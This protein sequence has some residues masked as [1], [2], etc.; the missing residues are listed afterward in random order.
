MNGAARNREVDPVIRPDRAEAL[1]GAA[2]LDGGCDLL[3]PCHGSAGRI[4]PVMISAAGGLGLL[5]HPRGHQRL[6]VVIH[7][8]VDATFGEAEAPDPRLPGARARRNE[9]VI[10]RIVD[11]L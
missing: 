2:A 5:P 4:R 3:P 8:I 7:C 9:G 10:D 6:V 11:P 1:V